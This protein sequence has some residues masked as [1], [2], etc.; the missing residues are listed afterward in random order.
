MLVVRNEKVSDWVRVVEVEGIGDGGGRVK[1][2]DVVV[3]VM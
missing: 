2:G 3:W 1:G